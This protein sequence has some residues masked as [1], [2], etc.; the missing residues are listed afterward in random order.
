MEAR[1]GWIVTKKAFASAPSPLVPENR[2]NQPDITGTLSHPKGIVRNLSSN[3][4][5]ET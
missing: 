1:R 4:R 3:S 5:P 2:H